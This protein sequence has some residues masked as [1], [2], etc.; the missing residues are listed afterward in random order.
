MSIDI[1]SR[2]SNL[3]QPMEKKRNDL[4]TILGI[5]SLT[6]PTNHTL[7]IEKI[8][9]T[10]FKLES[11]NGQETE[12]QIKNNPTLN[13]LELVLQPQ[14]LDFSM[15]HIY[16]S[17]TFKCDSNLTTLKNDTYLRVNASGLVLSTLKLN[18]PMYGG[19]IEITRGLNQTID[20]DPFIFTYDIDA[21]AIITQLSFKYTCQ[22]VIDG[23]SLLIN[24]SNFVY[25]D[26]VARNKSLSSSACFSSTGS[27]LFFKY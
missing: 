17:V 8:Q 10:I 18:Q 11:K 19:T 7:S 24:N 23:V 14:T 21:K 13:Y 20:F 16:F 1:Q 27:S 25:L 4:I 2:C 15:Y 3:L 9:W 5:I 12:V 6:K 26:E 22:V